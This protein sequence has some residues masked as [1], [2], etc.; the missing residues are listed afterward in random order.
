M[1]I[2]AFMIR[3]RNLAHR[4]G[5]NTVLRDINLDINKGAIAAIMGSSGGGKTTLLRCMAGL[6]KPSEGA[7]E[8]L[9]KDIWK[10]SEEEFG[11]IRKHIGV[12]FQGAALFDYLNVFDNIVFGAVRQRKYKR[13]ELEE[14]VSEMLEMVG[15]EGTEEKYPGELSGGMKKRVGLARALA[16]HPDI[17][18][19]DEPTSGLDPIIAY[20]IDGLIAEIRE[21]VQATSIIVSHDLNSVLRVAHRI[22]FLFEGEIIADDTPETFMQSKDPRIKELVEKAEATRV[23]AATKIST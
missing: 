11:E 21:R 5:D 16:T 1:S 18:F 10:M 7:V 20:A 23:E 8:I 22:I 14:L 19:Y 3:V 13:Q 2:L 17:L 15:L 6:L 4:F 12:V 9:D